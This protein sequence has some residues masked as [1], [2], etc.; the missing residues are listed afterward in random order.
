M[1]KSGQWEI[2][3]KH[4]LNA[5]AIADE[6]G[7]AQVQAETRVELAW[8]LLGTG[9][10]PSAEQAA[11]EALGHPYLP[12]RAGSALVAG[13]VRLL[14]GELPAAELR[15]QDAV[16]RAQEQLRVNPQSYH[17][18]DTQA[19]ALAG[20][21]LTG[22]DDRTGDAIAAFQAARA[23]TTAYGITARFLRMFAALSLADPTGRLR[24]LEVA[25]RSGT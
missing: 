5:R 1:R 22:A 8:A 24:P 14:R 23:V 25:T 3:V 18:L 7:H 2:A 6:I 9:D 11:E 20:L 4:L 17:M 21:T 19:L 12:A 15:L 10:L 16:R 13:V